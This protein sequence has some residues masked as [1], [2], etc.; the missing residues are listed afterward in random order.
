M[1]HKY[2][3]R[4]Q[5]FISLQLNKNKSKK[6]QHY[7]GN[8]GQT[9]HPTLQQQFERHSSS[10]NGNNSSNDRN[11]R[12]KSGILTQNRTK[13]KKLRRGLGNTPQ[14][15]MRSG[16]HNN[17]HNNNN[18]GPTINPSTK[19]QYSSTAPNTAPSSMNKLRSHSTLHTQ[20]STTSINSPYSTSI[21]SPESVKSHSLQS[22]SRNTIKTQPIS[23]S[24]QL[25]P[26]H[27]RVGHPHY[28]NKQSSS[29]S[30]YRKAPKTN[31]QI[32]HQQRKKKKK[33]QQTQQ[34]SHPNINAQV[35][36]VLNKLHLRDTASG[37][38]QSQSTSQS[39]S[40][41]HINANYGPPIQT[42]Q[43]QPPN[44]SPHVN[45]QPHQ[46][47]HTQQSSGHSQTFD[48]NPNSFVMFNAGQSHSPI[49]PESD[50]F[51]HIGW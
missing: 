5:Y 33:K 25:K 45:L 26:N 10:G 19:I 46:S 15:E 39:A 31:K 32:K 49:E 44:H 43:P 40:Q 24:P 27:R 30:L 50:P 42:Q 36:N 28:K 22:S 51:T 6:Q 14:P 7:R 41:H 47:N 48:T 29:L 37:T 20:S 35:M 34:P 11:L 21:N 38:S 2:Y 16:D 3:S 13:G 12:S 4:L 1:Y 23:H 8:M 17:N 9:S 18:N